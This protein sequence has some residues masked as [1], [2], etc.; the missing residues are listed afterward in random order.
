MQQL[1]AGT[2]KVVMFPKGQGQPTAFPAGI[3]IT[4]DEFGNTYAFRP[5]LIKRA[6]ITTAARNNTLPEILGGPEG[7]GAP[8][9]SALPGPPV[10]VVAKGPDGTEA[11]TTVTDAVTR[12]GGTINIP[13]QVLAEMQGQSH[14]SEQNRPSSIADRLE[15]KDQATQDFNRPPD[16][17]ASGLYPNK[18]KKK[19]SV[20]NWIYWLLVLPCRRP[21]PGLTPGPGTT[22]NVVKQK[23]G[24]N[25]SMQAFGFVGSARPEIQTWKSPFYSDPGDGQARVILLVTKHL[26]QLCEQHC[27]RPVLCSEGYPEVDMELTLSNRKSDAR[28]HASPAR[29]AVWALWALLLISFSLT[30]AAIVGWCADVI[31]LPEIFAAGL[32]FTM[33]SVGM[34]VTF[35]RLAR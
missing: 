31:S 20:Q 32:A 15:M 4:H 14:T 22:S 1:G 27:P 33:V 7:M 9:K 2:R 17:T 19:R 11:Q 24:V 5:D 35:W 30:D 29:L 13:E 28:L 10:A 16:Q 18:R 21:A 8:D 23:H 26:Q 25:T 6:A 3:A 12:E 34:I